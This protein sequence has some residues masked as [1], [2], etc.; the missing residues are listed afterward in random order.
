M[1]IVS[2]DQVDFSSSLA[3]Q[4]Y[5]CSVFVFLNVNL[6]EAQVT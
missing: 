6:K 2:L 3:I 4:Q 1:Q 5:N